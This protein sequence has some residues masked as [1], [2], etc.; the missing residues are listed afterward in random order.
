MEHLRAS[1]FPHYGDGDVDIIVAHGQTY[2]LHSS[3]LRRYS[4]YFAQ[5]LGE[6]QG[7]SL[8]NKAKKDGVTT[9]YRLQLVKTQLGTIGTFQRL[10]SKPRPLCS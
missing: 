4:D 3:V 10:V 7:A 9:R 1:D 2:Q 6:D 8:S 5:V